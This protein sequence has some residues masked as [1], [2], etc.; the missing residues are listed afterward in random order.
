[1]ETTEYIKALQPLHCSRFVGF[2]VVVVVV[3]SAGVVVVVAGAHDNTIKLCR[4]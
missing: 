3:L 2:I 4:S 1:M